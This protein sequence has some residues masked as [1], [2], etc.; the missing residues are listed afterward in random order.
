[1]RSFFLFFRKAAFGPN[2]AYCLQQLVE[3][4][5]CSDE[6]LLLLEAA[7]EDDERLEMEVEV[8]VDGGRQCSAVAEEACE[9]RL[10]A[11]SVLS[12]RFFSG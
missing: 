3:C 12:Q 7:E 8:E 10:M 9:F 5:W 6:Q 1:M 2:S 4:C 11:E